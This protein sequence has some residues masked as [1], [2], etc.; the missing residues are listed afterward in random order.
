MEI[1]QHLLAHIAVIIVLAKLFSVL[2]IKFKEPA[3]LGMLLV[4]MVIGPT[5]FDLIETNVVLEIFSEI[6]VI[7]LLF[8]AG[9]ETDIPSMKRAGR[10]ALFSSIGG[11]V[12]PF[13]SGFALSILFGLSLEKAL[14][15]GVAFT[16]TSVSVTVM[17]LMDMKKFRTVEGTTI[18][19]AA[20]IDDVIG[21]LLLTIVF[22]FFGG[23][24][25]SFLELIFAITGYVFIGLL[26]AKFLLKKII[27]LS[28]SVGSNDMELSIGL[29][30]ALLY[31]W[32][33]KIV[34]MASITGAYFSGLFI[35]QTKSKT[36][37]SEGI[38]EI[39]QSLFVPV[40][41]INIGLTTN[42]R[43]GSFNILFAISFILVA[44]FSKI[45]GGGFGAKLNGFGYKRSLIIGI[46][47]VPRGEVALVIANMA[48]ARKIISAD[49]FGM[50]VMMVVVSAIITPLLLKIV[51]KVEKDGVL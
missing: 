41:F 50:I 4:G 9:L 14:I 29:S 19:G 37:I 2:S 25:K 39:G 26:F 18:M 16:A 15:I 28:R 30:L 43:E 17:T 13:L 45:I 42:L 32:G 27:K 22:S 34:G 10:G 6:G 7:I 20:I 36:K 5:G 11:I 33:A 38:K 8:E 46:G 24:E 31:S 44:I 21:I 23:N 35:A 1:S 3:V 48:M 47:L 40:F 12:F 49:I 51:C